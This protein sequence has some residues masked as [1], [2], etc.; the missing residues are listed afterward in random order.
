[1]EVEIP[2]NDWSK[3]RLRTGKVATSRSKRYGNPGDTF[4]F[5]GIKYK[6]ILVRQLPLWFIRDC[7]WGCEGAIAPWEFVTE[8]KKIHYKKGWDD[9]REV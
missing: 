5:D 6:I 3:K 9:K 1:M 2:F 7:L 4:V 8:W